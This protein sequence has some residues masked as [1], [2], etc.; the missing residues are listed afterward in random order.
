MGDCSSKP[1][2]PRAEQATEALQH[3]VAELKRQLAAQRAD[4]G[5]SRSTPTATQ[6]QAKCIE[7]QVSNPCG[8]DDPVPAAEESVP[9]AASQAQPAALGDQLP[10]TPGQ[11]LKPDWGKKPLLVCV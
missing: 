3:E 10:S 9:P 4:S 5:P 8:M 11:K 7:D 6:A 2:D 1:E